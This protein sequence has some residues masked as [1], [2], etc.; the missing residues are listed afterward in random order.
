MTAQILAP[1]TINI[2]Q[3]ARLIRAGGLVG[4][5]TETVYGLAADAA[6]GK[7]VASIYAAKGRPSFNPL[8]SHVSGL[9]MGRKLAVFSPL[10]EELAHAFWPGPLTLVLPRAADCP[11]SELV[12]AGLDTI[13]VRAPDHPVALALI[14]A[15]DTPL[16][17]PSANPSERLSPT[18]ARHVAAGLGDKLDV[19]LDGGPCRAGVES[20][21][22]SL[23][24]PRPALLRPGA[25]ARADI[26]AITGPLDAPGD[27]I[28]SPG[29]LR[30]HYAP[31]A[32]LRLNA[33]AP[34]PDEAFLAFGPTPHQAAANLSESGDL[35]EAASNLFSMLRHLDDAHARI[36]VA[37]I[38]H[39]GLGEAINDR[40]T[41][42]AR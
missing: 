1:D 26:E 35:T 29:M 20:T 39:T 38:P 40:L 31:N 13:A 6:N 24:G 4:M 17:A 5:P 22:V 41:R 8:I 32:R 15:A 12:T 25:L 2:A 11:V 34:Q 33:E 28:A 37:P 10:A 3:A 23:A 42:A 7:A 19:I 16:A 18:T 21:V 27:T 36:A 9:K 14:T 30:R